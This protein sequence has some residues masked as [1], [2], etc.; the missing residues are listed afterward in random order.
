MPLTNTITMSSTKINVYKEFPLI[1]W[2]K[3]QAFIPKEV[4]LKP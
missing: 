2:Q 4:T 1:N 3:R